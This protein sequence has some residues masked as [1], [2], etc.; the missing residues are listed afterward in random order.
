MKFLSNIEFARSFLSLI[1]FAW[2]IGIC[3]LV[4]N[5]TLSCVTSDGCLK[6]QCNYEWLKPEYQALIDK[7][8]Y[9]CRNRVLTTSS[10]ISTS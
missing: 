10:P 7:N 1:I 2:I 6:S 9:K 8:S 5:H 4:V 3:L